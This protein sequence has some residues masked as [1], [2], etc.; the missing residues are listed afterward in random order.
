MESHSI[1]RL[2]RLA[3]SACIFLTIAANGFLQPFVPLFLYAS[4]LTKAQ[5][6]LVAGVASGSAL[7]IQPLLG[8]LSDRLDARR[9][10][11]FAAGLLTCAAYMGYC[12]AI[13]LP[14]FLILTILGANGFSY[15]NVACGVLAG[16]AAPNP[17]LA[18]RAY[19]GYRVWGSIGYIIISLT[20]GLYLALHSAHSGQSMNRES[21]LAIFA[22]GPLVF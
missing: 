19:A 20:S 15:L 10:L 17:S 1:S 14:A 12:R 2:G 3:L 5:I 13:T 11:M 22:L 4:A 9:P 6:G 8:V 7:L 21:L 18:G 16:R